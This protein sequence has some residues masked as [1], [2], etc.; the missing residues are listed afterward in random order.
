[1]HDQIKGYNALESEDKANFVCQIADYLADPA[2]PF[3]NF[4]VIGLFMDNIVPRLTRDPDLFETIQEK[5][6]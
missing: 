2:I 6:G 5:I 3:K 1:M 4:W